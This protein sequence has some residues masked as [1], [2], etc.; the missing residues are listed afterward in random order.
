M[1]IFFENIKGTIQNLNSKCDSTGTM[2]FKF[3]YSWEN[4]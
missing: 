2:T 4:N 1:P 3:E